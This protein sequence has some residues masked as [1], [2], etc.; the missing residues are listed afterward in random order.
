MKSYVR[1]KRIFGCVFLH[2]CGKID[3]YYITLHK[4][5][6]KNDTLRKFLHVRIAYVNFFL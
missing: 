3:T 4:K 6:H 2:L 5:R 1:K